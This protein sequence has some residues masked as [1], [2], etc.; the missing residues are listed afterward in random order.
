MTTSTPSVNFMASSSN[1][2]KDSTHNSINPNNT[3][4]SMI[5]IITNNSSLNN[6]SCQSIRR[7]NPFNTQKK[8]IYFH[9]EQLTPTSVIFTQSMEMSKAKSGNDYVRFNQSFSDITNKSKT[10]SNQN[11]DSF[12]SGSVNK[13][14]TK[15]GEKKSFKKYT[16]HA[17]NQ[18]EKPNTNIISEESELSFD[19]IKKNSKKK[20]TFN[21]DHDNKDFDQ[22]KFDRSLEEEIN[23]G[24][25][26]EVDEER[27]NENLTNKIQSYNYNNNIKNIDNY[28]G[29]DC[30]INYREILIAYYSKTI[31]PKIRHYTKQID[32]MEKEIKLIEEYRQTIDECKTLINKMNE[33]NKGF[34]FVKPNNNNTNRNNQNLNSSY[35]SS[36]NS[37]VDNNNDNE[38]QLFIKVQKMQMMYSEK[39]RKFRILLSKL[40]NA[41]IASMNNNN[42][43]NNITNVKKENNNIKDNH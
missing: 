5:P 13:T 3:N 34:L 42:S 2:I 31:N 26:G 28:L 40:K 38:D 19:S 41:L 25:G 39:K 11:T 37:D 16:Y 30:S 22:E 6:S 21:L 12:I 20:T 14:F 33:L 32:I 8:S 36:Y 9:N 18:S 4:D 29:I 23:D 15:G 27:T 7:S 43:G 24:Q 17:L 1:I 10:K 35:A